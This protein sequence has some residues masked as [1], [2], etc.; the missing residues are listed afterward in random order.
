MSRKKLKIEPVQTREEMEEIV[1]ELCELSIQ[2][3]LLTA[4]RDEYIM[5]VRE[6]Y[7]ASLAE[8]EPRIARLLDRAESWADAHPEEFRGKSI[9]MTHGIVG[10]R[11]GTP[12]L[13]TLA[14]WT[15]AKV[16]DA[17]KNGPRNGYWR[18]GTR[19]ARAWRSTG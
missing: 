16:L 3:D 18:T 12:K 4:Q 11:T 9:E 15:W 2:Q 10:Y 13:V 5:E 6:R 7:K 1:R 19:S 8:I 17:L 14:R